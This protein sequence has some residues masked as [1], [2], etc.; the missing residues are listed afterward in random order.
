LTARHERAGLEA[1]IADG[2][3]VPTRLFNGEKHPLTMGKHLV[4]GF[5]LG[6]NRIEAENAAKSLKDSIEA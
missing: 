3:F 2:W 5:V 4:N 6:H 1:P